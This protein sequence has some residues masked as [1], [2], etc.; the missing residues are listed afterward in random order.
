[1]T[2]YTVLIPKLVNA[3]NIQDK[4]RLELVESTKYRPMVTDPATSKLNTAKQRL[5]N[6]RTLYS[7]DIDNG[8]LKNKTYPRKTWPPIDARKVATKNWLGYMLNQ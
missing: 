8:I 5:I 6:F 1:M 7:N 4:A 3:S 2:Q